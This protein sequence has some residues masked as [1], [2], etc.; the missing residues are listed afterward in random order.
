MEALDKWVSSKSDSMMPPYLTRN[1]AIFLVANGILTWRYLAE[2]LPDELD[3]LPGGGSENNGRF[4]ARKLIKVATADIETEILK[5]SSM[6]RRIDTLAI[7]KYASAE[8]Q[9]EQL[10]EFKDA[11]MS[12]DEVKKLPQANDLGEIYD[13]Q[14]KPIE[15]IKRLKVAHECG[16]DVG[17]YMVDMADELFILSRKGSIP[18]TISHLRAWHFFSVEL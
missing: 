12:R 3:E 5:E 13:R 2:V 9:A 7:S 18:S 17:G 14:L 4:L 10:T 15:A 8:R 6:K 1:T 11:D 16:M